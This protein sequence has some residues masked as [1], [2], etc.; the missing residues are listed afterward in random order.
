MSKK[1]KHKKKIKSSRGS[2]E[3]LL[4]FSLISGV[5]SIVSFVADIFAMKEEN[6]LDDEREKKLA[7]YDML[8]EALEE[9]E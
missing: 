7:K 5:S 8:L 2:M 1:K 6:K 3:A 9:D 4:V